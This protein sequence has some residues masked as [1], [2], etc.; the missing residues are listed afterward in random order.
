MSVSCYFIGQ[1]FCYPIKYESITFLIF[2][3]R[4]LICFIRLET[5][6]DLVILYILRINLNDDIG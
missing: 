4:N 5:R 2:V 3:A 1:S 6:I